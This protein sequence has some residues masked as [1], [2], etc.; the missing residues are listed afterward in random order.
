MIL[1]YNSFS[2]LI[3][4]SISI[5]FTELLFKTT[6]RRSTKASEGHAKGAKTKI[7]PDIINIGGGFPTIY[8]DLVPQ[9]LDSYFEEI[10][11]ALKNLKLEKLKKL[12]YMV[13]AF[14]KDLSYILKMRLKPHTQY[15][16]LVK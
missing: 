14:Q 11:K 5:S 8:P 16:L 6:L 10:N 3:Q 1:L 4:S 15:H 7:L 12:I 9:S 13:V 2:S